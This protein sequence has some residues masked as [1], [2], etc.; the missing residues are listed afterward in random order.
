MT[1]LDRLEPFQYESPKKKLFTLQFDNVVRSGG[2]KIG[3]N[4]FPNQNITNEQELGNIANRFP[5]NCYLTGNDYDRE[6]DRFWKALE[7]NGVGKLDHPRWGS[8][9]V[10]PIT[11]TQTE[12]FVDGIGRANF[13]IEFIRYYPESKGFFAFLSAPFEIIELVIGAID[14]VLSVATAVR[15]LGRGIQ[16]QIGTARSEVNRIKGRTS[17]TLGS[18]KKQNK[19]FGVRAKELRNRINET[20][21]SIERN[22]ES[23]AQDP[24]RLVSQMIVLFRLPALVTSSIR[25]KVEGYRD[26]LTSL[27]GQLTATG[28]TFSEYEATIQSCVCTAA[29]IALVES[30][31][32]GEVQTRNESVS[33]ADTLYESS[34]QLKTIYDSCEAFGG[35]VDYSIYKEI[36]KTITICQKLII[37]RAINLPSERSVVLDG[38][39]SPLKFCYETLGNALLVDSFIDYNR[40]SGNEILLMPPGKTVRY[41]PEVTS[42]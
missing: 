41:I 33:I 24:A 2:K 26:L 39:I 32:E 3:I 34:L 40:L 11:Y 31:L 15:R 13:T 28:A 9:D 18:F 25:A 17:D 16:R 10:I 5:V 29:S 1:F 27:Q 12:E 20:Q 38:E 23:L 30:S 42:T 36:Q 8:Y 7:E 14:S 37:D 35:N 21:K 4:E 19:N 22:I 6:A